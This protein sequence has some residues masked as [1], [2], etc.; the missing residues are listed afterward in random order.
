MK[1]ILAV[2][3]LT[4]CACSSQTSYTQNQSYKWA[5]RFCGTNKDI[6]RFDIDKDDYDR[7][8]CVDG[9]SAFVPNT[10]K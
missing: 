10:Q 6:S 5:E 3:V 1:Y 7:V 9:R 8:I 4:L 2:A